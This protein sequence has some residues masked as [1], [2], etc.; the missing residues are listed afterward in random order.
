MKKRILAVFLSLMLLFSAFAGLASVQADEVKTDFEVSLVKTPTEGSL[1]EY[2]CFETK[3][4]WN[5]L[6]TTFET[7]ENGDP[8]IMFDRPAGGHIGYIEDAYGGNVQNLNVPVADYVGIILSVKVEKN[9]KMTFCPND[10]HIGEVKLYN[11]NSDKPEWVEAFGA[12]ADSSAPWEQYIDMP[13]N[14]NGYVYISFDDYSKEAVN[15]VLM[16]F[17]A[18]GGEYGRV[19]VGNIYGVVAEPDYGYGS[20]KRL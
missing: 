15:W 17:W 19:G 18:I 9:Q 20:V 13:E 6:K 8:F 2:L 1:G 14:F 12:P 4:P 16:R 3:A 7:D 11:R 10:S 5:E